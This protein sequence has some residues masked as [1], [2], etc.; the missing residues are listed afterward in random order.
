MGIFH[1][2][3]Y[4][5]FLLISN[6]VIGSIILTAL[7]GTLTTRGT[8]RQNISQTPE[9][10][11]VAMRLGFASREL[12]Q[13]CIGSTKLGLCTFYLRIFQDRLSKLLNWCLMG[14]IATF[15]LALSLGIIFQ[16]RPIYGTVL[17]IF[18]YLISLLILE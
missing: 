6:K 9:D 17:L 7:N 2:L 13:V 3:I 1:S 11:V 4:L 18:S 15:T 16:C 5:V 10:L 14:F 8:S 12:Y